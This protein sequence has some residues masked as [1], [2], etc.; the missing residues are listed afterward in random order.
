MKFCWHKYTEW[1]LMPQYNIQAYGWEL[2]IYF[3]ICKKCGK[4]KT[5][6]NI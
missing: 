3:K 1:K 5:R 2:P 6:S 4:I